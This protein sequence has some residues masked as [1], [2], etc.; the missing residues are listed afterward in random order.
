MGGVALPERAAGARRGD[1]GARGFG[2]AGAEGRF[3]AGPLTL[4]LLTLGGLVLLA[5]VLRTVNVEHYTG[6]F[7][8]GIRMQQLLLMELGYR[9]FRDIFAS[10][11]PLLLDLLYPFYRLF[12]QTIGA[13]RL[14]V[15]LLSLLG[16]VGAWWALRPLQ[17]LAGLG[18]ALLLALSTRY[19]ENSRLALAEIPSLAPCLWA[20]GCA[21]RWQ[22]GG[23]DGWL[24]AAAALATIG[25]LIKPMVVPIVVPLALL[26][27][28]RRPLRPRALVLA[29]ATAAGL[30]A[31]TLAALDLPRVLEVLGAFRA[32]AQG[33]PGS[34]A[35]ENLTLIRRTLQTERW[36]FLALAALGVALGTAIWPRVGLALAA[37]PL[38]QLLLFVL[39]TDLADKHVVYLVPPLALLG[40]LACGGAAAALVRA[41]ASRTTGWTLA[42]LAGLAALA[43]YV[44]T[45]PVVW[46]ADLALLIDDDERTRRDYAGTAEQAE[47]M[48]ALTAPGE[49]VLSDHPIA[50]FYAR[51]PVPPWLVDTSG[52]RVD[53]GSLT[54]EVAIR[55]AERF[56][57][58]VVV[59]QRRRLGKL[60]GFM[61]WLARDYRMVRTYDATE[62][63]L[64]LYVRADLEERARMFLAGR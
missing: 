47:L 61:R 14:G 49:F 4:E 27:L 22:R 28:L 24:Y 43:L 63:P 55:E 15:G 2:Q 23:A 39:Y 62:P 57:P 36:G 41:R 7:D 44:S 26:A 60:D 33:A 50:A 59:V 16:L 56:G 52:T 1:A 10:Q 64:Q 31:V 34:D 40:G 6:S 48:A 51:R 12:G 29:A 21:L 42:G 5:G 19:L 35:G 8:E 3:R 9:P 38:A 53:A 20:L 46:R 18:A 37:W 32:G 13:A 25:V 58:K 45:L 11:G 54:S 30:A 17:P